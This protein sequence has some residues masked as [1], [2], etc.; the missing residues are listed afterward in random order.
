MYIYICIYICIYIYIVV[1]IY[2]VYKKL[3]VYYVCIYIYKKYHLYVKWSSPVSF[4]PMKGPQ[5]SIGQNPWNWVVEVT[6]TPKHHTTIGGTS[7]ISTNFPCFIWKIMCYPL[8]LRVASHFRDRPD[9]LLRIPLYFGAIE[10]FF[11]IY[12]NQFW[13]LL[14]CWKDGVRLEGFQLVMGVL[15]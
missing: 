14:R 12:W 2:N 4:P 13:G 3:C 9:F 5:T 7:R 8:D 10:T 1:Y 6:H 15:P 11:I